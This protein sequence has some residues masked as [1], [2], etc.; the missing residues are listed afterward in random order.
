MSRSAP[1]E[2]RKSLSVD[3][4]GNKS[5]TAT[6]SRRSGRGGNRGDHG[7]KKIG[8]L[9]KRSHSPSNREPGRILKTRKSRSRVTSPEPITSDIAEKIKSERNKDP[10]HKKKVNQKHI[11][12]FYTI[13]KE[14]SLYKVI[15]TIPDDPPNDRSSHNRSGWEDDCKRTASLGAVTTRRS[16]HIP[17]E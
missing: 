15:R 13:K 7:S 11:T 14:K 17:D 5:G 16:R 8:G 3:S 2:L 1:P 6:N 10:S 4:R 12:E 9:K